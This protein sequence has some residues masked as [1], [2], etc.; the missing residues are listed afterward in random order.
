MCVFWRA[1]VS[2]VCT[3]EFVCVCVYRVEGHVRGRHMYYN[4]C[5][6]VCEGAY[7]NDCESC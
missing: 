5:V 6:C 3:R 4:L 1:N 2:T 7:A